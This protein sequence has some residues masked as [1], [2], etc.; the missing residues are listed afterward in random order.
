MVAGLRAERACPHAV[1]KDEHAVAVKAA[2]DGARSARPEAALRHAR[3]LVEHLAERRVALLGDADRVERGHGLKRLERRLLAPRRRHRHLF[4]VARQLHLE[5]ERG[6]SARGDRHLLRRV[7]EALHVREHGVR[8]GRDLLKL[9]G[10]VLVRL[11][12]TSELD[13]G[14]DDVVERRAALG[15]RDRAAH[16][17]AA[18]RLGERRNAVKNERER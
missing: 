9:V 12:R 15:Q 16:G 5:V 18:A 8:A 11:L 7:G 1:L 14:D 10:A 13:D 17:A 2:D 3:L 6:R 4:A